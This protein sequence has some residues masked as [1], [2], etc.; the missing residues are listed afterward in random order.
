MQYDKAKRITITLP[1]TCS[2]KPKV[3]SGADKYLHEIHSYKS[4]KRISQTQ[5]MIRV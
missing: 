1:P 2:L 3:S 5:G 4:K